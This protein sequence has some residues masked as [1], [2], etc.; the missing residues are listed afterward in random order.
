MYTRA[1]VAMKHSPVSKPFAIIV[2]GA[3]AVLGSLATACVKLHIDRRRF[4]H[5]V[6]MSREALEFERLKFEHSKERL[7]FERDWLDNRKVALSDS[8]RKKW[9]HEILKVACKRGGSAIEKPFTHVDASVLIQSIFDD[10]L[11]IE[12]TRE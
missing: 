7:A 1:A 10:F 3:V 9:E 6:C 4:E 12:S 5:D 8:I 2:L 11:S